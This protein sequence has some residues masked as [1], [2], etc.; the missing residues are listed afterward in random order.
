VG[1]KERGRGKVGEMTH[2]LYAHVNK[3]K[4]KKHKKP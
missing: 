1:V 2:P 4:I 3:I